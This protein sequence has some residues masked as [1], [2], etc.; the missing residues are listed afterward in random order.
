MPELWIVR[1]GP[2]EG[3]RGVTIRL[4]HISKRYRLGQR[5]TVALDDVSI[6]VERGEILGLI[7]HSGA[8]KSTLLRCI[9]L[10]ERPSSGTVTVDGVRLDT[11]PERELQRQR[12]RMGMIFQHFHLLSS[13]TV[14]ENVA[15]PLRLAGVSRTDRE[16]RVREVLHWVGLAGFEDK[17]PSQLSGG[18]KQRVAIARAL[19]PGPDVLLCDEATSALDPQTTQTILDLLL[20]AQRELGVTLVVVTHD[21]SVVQRICDRVVVMHRG[22]VVET[23]TAADVLLD[24]RHE[25][26][27]ELVR[28]AGW[29]MTGRH[30]PLMGRR[31]VLTFVGD[32]VYEP[33]LMRVAQAAGV[34]FSIV[35]GRI[36]RLK[37]QPFGR[38]VVDWQGT[39]E[40]WKRAAALLEAL[41]VSVSEAVTTG[42]R[43]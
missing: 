26:T 36:D 24:P 9:N 5:E 39:D 8:G 19:A 30:A 2:A 3:R 14:A 31:T 20:A 6:T 1:M 33:V 37:V 17:Y 23:G 32:N 25:L 22:R 7:G 16:R 11:L 41:G 43:G 42:S 18:Q 10:L 40:Q 13:A 38:I 21:M 35:E 34:T 28:E 27:R 4:E 12:R 15:F 29:Q